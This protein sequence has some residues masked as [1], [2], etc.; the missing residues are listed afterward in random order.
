MIESLGQS[1]LRPPPEL[2]CSRLRQPASTSIFPV[3]SPSNQL[4]CSAGTPSGGG[5]PA[6]RWL[7]CWALAA[8]GAAAAAAGEE[9]TL[10]LDLERVVALALEQNP[11]LRAETERRLEVAGGVEEAGADAWPQID[12]VGSWSRSRNPA[13]LNSPD[14][15]D[16][17]AQFP[18]FEPGEQELWDLGVELTQ[19]VYSG[20]KVR[21]AIDLAELVVDI[22]DAQIDAAQLATALRA[23]EAYFRLLQARGEL[24]TIEIQRR[25]RRRSLEVVEGR[26][27]LGAATRLEALRARSAL[28][29]VEPTVAEISGRVDVEASRLRTALGLEPATRLAAEP[30]RG[31][32]PE[33]PE[34]TE[35]LALAR[36]HRPELRDLRLQAEALGRRRVVTA[37]DGRPQVELAG[38]YGR[39]VR[40]VDDFGDALFDNWRV[41]LGVT[42][43]LFDG[44]RRRGQ[45][46]QLESRRQQ[47]E[48]QLADLEKGI[49][50]EI[51]ESLVEYRTARERQR[52]AEI[53]AEAAREASR[54]ALESYREGAA[55]QADLLDAQEEE[56]Q[57]EFVLVD[58]FYEA[59][60]Q[61]VRLLRAVGRLPTQS[62]EETG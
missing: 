23:A 13:L 32:L 25:A 24:E 36:E 62:W 20:G 46:A 61:A 5:S 42:W 40:L 52:S 11:A 28:A 48:W 33:P 3:S 51:E 21:A 56:I 55:L 2:L 6:V 38:A 18:G 53:A 50:S 26:F 9:A 27:E 31:E 60:I 54:V 37:A 1:D 41:S 59:W 8:L 45:L 14:F 15:D 43:S 44:G 12:L 7:A 22:T 16:I 10:R 39:Q 57:A 34:I 49:A 35:L 17:V 4:G 19:T 58:A 47:L 30:A 29:A